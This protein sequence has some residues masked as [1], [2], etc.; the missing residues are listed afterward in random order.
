MVFFGLKY[1]WWQRWAKWQGRVESTVDSIVIPCVGNSFV[2]EGRMAAEFAAR[3]MSSTTEIILATDQ[4]ASAFNGLPAKV[5][6]VELS[7]DEKG[8]GGFQAIWRSRLIKMQAPLLANGET[9][10][11]MDSDINL[12]RDF[13]LFIR[14]NT[15]FG[16]FRPGKM[17]RKVKH[18]KSPIPE[19]EG[20]R[21]ARRKRHL[22]GGFLVASR[23]TWLRLA[24][25]WRCLYL[26]LWRRVGYETPPTDQLPLAASIEQLGI[27]AC[28]LGRPYNHVVTEMFD[29]PPVRIPEGIIGAHGGLPVREWKKYLNDPTAELHFITDKERRRVRYLSD[30]EAK[31]ESAS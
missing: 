11:L 7:V 13:K 30:T 8:G 20:V 15:I 27:S 1:R 6:V 23:D 4:S 28:D 14:P 18:H 16:A 22:N 12:L 10:L 19:L 2:E 26:A 17:I 24:P 21:W 29:E 3:H 9:I 25:A 31:S 5:R